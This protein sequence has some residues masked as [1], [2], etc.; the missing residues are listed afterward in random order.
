MSVS[1]RILIGVAG[2]VSGV[3][4]AVLVAIGVITRSDRTVAAGKRRFH[5]H[6]FERRWISNPKERERHAEVVAERLELDT[7][8]PGEVTLAEAAEQLGVTVATVRR[9]VKL[10][11]LQG[12]YRNGRLAGVIIEGG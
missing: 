8:E 2:A 5:G 10:G 12:V 6:A 11:K 1:R 4:G 7:V 3:I 9:R